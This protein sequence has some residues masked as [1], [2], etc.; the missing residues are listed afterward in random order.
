[1]NAPCKYI[2]KMVFVTIESN[3]TIE[4][5]KQSHPNYNICLVYIANVITERIL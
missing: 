4:F 2:S 3:Q 1:M 5:Y